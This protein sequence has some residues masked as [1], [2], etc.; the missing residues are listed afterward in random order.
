MVRYEV[1]NNSRAQSK[2]KF[3]VS[4]R[5]KRFVSLGETV[6]SRKA[7]SQHMRI[8]HQSTSN[9]A[10]H[11]LSNPQT[12]IHIGKE[13]ARLTGNRDMIPFYKHRIS[14]FET[15]KF[16]LLKIIVNPSLT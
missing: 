6:I 15:S 5:K 10:L 11:I 12:V 16:H 9:S 3:F 2:L 13:Q 4:L 7:F 14:D 1:C 8:A